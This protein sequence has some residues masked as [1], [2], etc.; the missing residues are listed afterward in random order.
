MVILI[1]E[2]E[3]ATQESQVMKDSLGK[4]E[5][6]RMI[7]VE[8][9]SQA[10]TDRTGVRLVVEAAAKTESADERNAGIETE[11]DPD[12]E[13]SMLALVNETFLD[14]VRDTVRGQRISL[15]TRV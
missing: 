8:I 3:E 9:V 15:I 10:I 7:V 12:L 1:D 13:M 2:T 5:I 14:Q 4:K 11:S 6:P